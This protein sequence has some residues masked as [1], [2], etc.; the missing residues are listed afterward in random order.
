MH[1]FSYSVLLKTKK[2]TDPQHVPPLSTGACI[3]NTLLSAEGVV[4]YSKMPSMTVVQGQLVSGLTML[5]SHTASLL[6]RHPA[7]LSALLQQYVKQQ[8]PDSS[9]EEAP[10]AEEAT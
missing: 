10:K 6:Q 5:T 4:S 8:S 7:H 2:P 1:L 9:A 3:E